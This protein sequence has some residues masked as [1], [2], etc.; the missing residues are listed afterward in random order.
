MNDSGILQEATEKLASFFSDVW[1]HFCEDH[2][3]VETNS[4]RL[5][6]RTAAAEAAVITEGTAGQTRKRFLVNSSIKR[7]CQRAQSR[8]QSL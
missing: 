7:R 8:K 3:M 1:P 2:D 6:D 4:E 5:S